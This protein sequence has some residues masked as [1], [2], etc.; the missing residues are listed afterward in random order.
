[1]VVVGGL[2]RRIRTE[3]EEGGRTGG[4]IACRGCTWPCCARG[5]GAVC[6]LGERMDECGRWRLAVGAGGSGRG[7]C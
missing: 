3:E 2:G 1:M 6:R 4:G 7:G 5:T